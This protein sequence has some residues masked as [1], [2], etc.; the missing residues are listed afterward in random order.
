MRTRQLIY[1]ISAFIILAFNSCAPAYV[2][3]VV[4]APLLT[5]KGEVQAAIHAGTSG[6]DPQ[7]AY[8]LSRHIGIM[9]N[10]SFANRTSDSTDN[11]HKHQFVEIATGYYTNFGARGKFETFCGIG[12]GKIQAEYENNLWVSFSDVSYNRFFIQPS[13]GFTSKVFD[14]SLSSR[15]VV[16]GLHQESG[17]STGCFFEPVVT[18]KLGFD[19][20]KAVA[21]LGLSFPLNSNKVVFTNQPLLLSLGLQANF[22]KIFK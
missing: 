18:G 7:F 19:H 5:N 16:V 6:V 15:F 20:I 3:N 2:P 8:A 4:N 14:G 9:L 12:T 22:G 1:S 13:I 11:F 17:S 21:Q 10:G